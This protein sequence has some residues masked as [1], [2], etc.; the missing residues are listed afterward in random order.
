MS[1]LFKPW[2]AKTLVAIALAAGIAPSVFAQNYPTKPVQMIV[3]FGPGAGLDVVARYIAERLAQDWKSSVVVDNRP[4]ASGAIAARA[5]ANAAP[6]GYTLLATSQVHYTN[7]LLYRSLP[8]RLSSLT[9]VARIGGTQL[10]LVVPANSPF[11]SLSALLAYAKANPTKLSYA[12]LG[13]GSSA[14]MAG[15]LLSSMAAVQLLHVPYKEGAQALA[16]TISGEVSL[17]FVAIATA[18]SQVKAGKLKALAVTGATRSQTMPEIPTVAESGLA[19]YD[20]IPWYVLLAPTGTPPT[21]IEKISSSVLAI[22]RTPEYGEVLRKQGLE[23]MVDGAA[24]IAQKLPG[25]VAK[26][27]KAVSATGLKLELGD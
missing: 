19:G 5:V 24:D 6:D 9:P 16:N 21:V 15:S 20:L 27:E 17:N 11:D 3:S 22:A 4:G 14:H 12:S 26:W 13:N 10:V 23:P 25:E 2:A 1:I 8:Y 7:A 18:M